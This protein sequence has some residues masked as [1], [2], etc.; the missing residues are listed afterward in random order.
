MNKVL[1][2][3]VM[4]VEE[5]GRALRAEFHL[6][7][8]PRGR[9]GNA[10][11]DTEIEERLRAK[12]QALVPCRF[13]GE[14]TGVSPAPAA[15]HEEWLWLVDPHDG[16]YEF[17]QGRRGSAISVC[18]LKN[19]KPVLAVVCSPLSP[20]RGWDTIAWVEGAGL[21]RN[22]APVEGDFSSAPQIVW[23]SAS[24]VLRPQ[25]FALAARP[26]RFAAMPSIAYRLARVAAG[27]GIATLST[28]GI[29]EYDFA[30]GLAMVT[31][32]GGV[33][34]DAEGKPLALE[35]DPERR[36]SG[37]FAGQAEAAQRVCSF[38]GGNLEQEP[39][40]PVRVHLGFPRRA[41]ELRL[42]R[43]AG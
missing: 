14:E 29:N 31:A 9:R 4:A 38:S 23:A 13:A 27:D 5:E 32:A 11:I 35:G 22:G 25:S 21:T 18:L 12:L 20:D 36:V 42:A 8:G 30:A 24:A 39:K 34:I 28:H 3:V 10:P 40:R 7:D 16:T 15:S 6:P 2:E 41:D 19:R 33:C 37:C 17:L 43:A 26:A 1:R